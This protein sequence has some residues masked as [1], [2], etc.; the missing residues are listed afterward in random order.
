MTKSIDQIIDDINNYLAAWDIKAALELAL[1]IYEKNKESIIVLNILWNIY[2]NKWE[3]QEA[4]KYLEEANKHSNEND[5]HVLFNL[6][7]AYSRIDKQK[8]LEYLN[9]ALSILPNEENIIKFKD[10]LWEQV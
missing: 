6:W 3:Y 8:S 7:V 9:K 5:W 10:S 4:V 2:L 1:S